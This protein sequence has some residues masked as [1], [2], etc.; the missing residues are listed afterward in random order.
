MKIMTI[1]GSPRRRG[2]TA[3]AL[4]IFEAAMREAK[5][6]VERVVLG[7]VTVKPCVSCWTCMKSQDA[8][9]CAIKDD[10]PKLFERMMAADAIVYATP[11]Y[12]WSFTA[13]MK[14]L[15]DR[16]VCMVKGFESAKHR[17]FLAGKKTALLVTCEGPIENN[18]DLIPTMFQR[19]AKDYMLMK[20]AGTFVITGCG[21]EPGSLPAGAEKIVKKMIKAF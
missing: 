21:M 5:H 11:L 9:G 4:D 16:H 20:S 10:A 13:Q 12:C 2:N 14:A 17:S 8:P 19:M 18:A 15:I 3:A 1:L 7:D 6:K